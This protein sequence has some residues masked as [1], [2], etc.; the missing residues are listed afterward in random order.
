[1]TYTTVVPVPD[2]LRWARLI[3]DEEGLDEASAELRALAACPTG[4]IADI[5]ARV[6][7]EGCRSNPVTFGE[8][9]ERGVE[10]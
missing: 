7:A 10:R 1:M 5:V 2:L 4:D 3:D 8:Q 9:R 6:R